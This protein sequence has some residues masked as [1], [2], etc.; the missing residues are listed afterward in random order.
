MRNHCERPLL[1]QQLERKRWLR[2]IA[3]WAPFRPSLRLLYH[4]VWKQGFRDGY[5]GWV[6]CRLLALV[7]AHDRIEGA[8]IKKWNAERLSRLCTLLSD[9]NSLWRQSRPR[10]ISETASGSRGYIICPLHPFHQDHVCPGGAVAHFARLAIFF[11][12][13]PLFGALR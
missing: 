7:R 4:Y 10:R 13:E 12:V 5:R 2:N 9:A 8:R 6:L 3:M 11:A 1:E